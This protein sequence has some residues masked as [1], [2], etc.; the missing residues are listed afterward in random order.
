MGNI[1]FFRAVWARWRHSCL[2]WVKLTLV[3]QSFRHRHS[4]R[5]SSCFCDNLKNPPS[6]LFYWLMVDNV[7]CKYVYKF[8]FSVLNFVLK[9]CVNDYANVWFMLVL[10]VY[11]LCVVC[12]VIFNFKFLFLL[13]YVLCFIYF[14]CI[15]GWRSENVALP[16]PILR[17]CSFCFW[18][19]CCLNKFSEC[20]T[21]FSLF[22][23][24]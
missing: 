9:L 1:C 20:Q 8:S 19:L 24:F 21:S 3:C 11:E 16:L 2:H 14:Y 12:V 7:M 13:L 18:C 5:S 15:W 23:S 6:A 10:E 22:P 17:I 4:W